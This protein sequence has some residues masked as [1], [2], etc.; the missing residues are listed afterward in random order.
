MILMGYLA[1]AIVQLDHMSRVA[2][3]KP[4][5]IID[6]LLWWILLAEVAAHSKRGS[7][8]SAQG[9]YNQWGPAPPLSSLNYQPNGDHER[10]SGR[11][12]TRRAS[13][14]NISESSDTIVL[15][16]SQMKLLAVVVL[17]QLAASPGPGM[18]RLIFLA[19]P[20]PSFGTGTDEA[21][22]LPYP[23][24]SESLLRWLRHPSAVRRPSFWH[25]QINRAQPPFEGGV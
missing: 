23:P 7:L 24:P 1:T 17:A 18:A 2:V 13:F 5:P 16:S 11:M 20:P 15:S 19:R 9:I 14:L 6:G 10:P 12:S 22:A 3:D 25:S 4:S 21:P 8:A